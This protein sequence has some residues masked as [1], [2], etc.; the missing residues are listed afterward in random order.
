MP[1]IKVPN[2]H[3]PIEP[4]DIKPS[5][6]VKSNWDLYEDGL[7]YS[8]L[9]S[10]LVCRE[11][12]RLR[13]VV[14]LQEIGS[15]EAMEFGTIFHLCL[16]MSAQGLTRTR[17]NAYFRNKN[18][19]GLYNP[20]LCSIA[21]TMLP[22]Y[23]EHW[24]TFIKKIHYYETEQEFR[25]PY[26]CSLGKTV[27]L[28]GIRDQGFIKNNK[29]WLQ[30]NKTKSEINEEVLMQTLPSMLQPM[31]Y[32]Y[33]LQ[34]LHDP[35]NIGGFI[36]NVIRKPGLRIGKKETEKKYIERI[37]DDIQKRPEHYF[38]MFEVEITEEHIELWKTQYLDPL[39]CQI[40]LW[41]ESIKSDPFNPW[42]VVGEDGTPRP[43]PHHYIR[44]FGIYDA[45]SRGIGDYFGPI[46]LGSNE[47]YEIVEAKDRQ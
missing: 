27:N 40:V 14:G 7:S 1:V 18:R 41:W 16:E 46:V 34:H 31:M 23:K 32:L 42:T 37:R 45:M 4:P 36:Y 43:N 38:K 10:F 44:P 24:K 20:R 2:P 12:F 33:S 3:M 25:I 39:I 17:I 11:R 21:L 5:P 35:A 22:L 26:T 13:K 47:G 6:K 28:I 15:K 8:S 30:E 9:S 29:V 19:Q